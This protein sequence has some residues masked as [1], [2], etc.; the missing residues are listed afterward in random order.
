[1][2]QEGQCMMHS[3]PIVSEVET[4]SPTASHPGG[5]RPASTKPGRMEQLHAMLNRAAAVILLAAAFW[6][7]IRWQSNATRPRYGELNACVLSLG[8]RTTPHNTLSTQEALGAHG[9]LGAHNAPGTHDVLGNH[10]AHGAALA[11]NTRDANASR[12]ANHPGTSIS[13]GETDSSFEIDLLGTP[14]D[15]V[16]L[17]RLTSVAGHEAIG[18]LNLSGT[19]VTD[20][21]LQHLARLDRLRR[22]DLR[23]LPITDRGLKHLGQCQKLEQLHLEGTK[24]T[25]EGVQRLSRVLPDVRILR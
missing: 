24:A 25:P 2:H 5:A 7:M 17:E 22:L 12:N 6:G 18:R 20:R 14:T 1:M 21:G 15:D 4:A 10:D 13:P 19:L 23:D 16:A 11:R 8:G 9:A 3:E